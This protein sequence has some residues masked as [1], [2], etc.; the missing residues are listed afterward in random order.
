LIGL[1]QALSARGIY[2]ETI[3]TDL[4]CDQAAGLKYECLTEF[5]SINVRYFPRSL[6][7][8]FPRD[9]AF[10]PRL[11]KWLR[12]HVQDYDIINIHGLFSYPN[13]IASTIAHRAKVPYVIR[14]CGM[15]DPW[16]LGQ[17]RIKK[18]AYL[19]LF[20]DRVLRHASAISFTSEEES[21][22]SYKVFPPPDSVIIPLGVSP[23]W[24][25]HEETAPLILPLDKQIILF[26]SR[27][28][29][30]KGLDLLLPALAR[31]KEERDDFLCVIAGGGRAPYE[32]KIK[33]EV[34]MN[35]LEDVIQFTGFVKGKRKK[36]LL[37]AASCFVLPSY[38]ENF[39][40]SVAEAMAAAC[41]V[42]ISDQVNI[43]KEVS[44]AF[45][46]R[47]VRCNVTDLFNAL[48]EVLS[49]ASSRREMGGNGQTLVKEK[50]NWDR[51]SEKV[52]SLYE[53]CIKRQYGQSDPSFDVPET[54]YSGN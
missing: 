27:L 37:Q 12:A 54:K 4:G 11:A 28:D 39:G 16:C 15:L 31:L 5:H 32:D 17:S 34:K 6:S 40:V 33:N 36:Q 21:R 44:T 13:S 47:V 50:F 20:E 48:N 29:E 2:S 46:G 53:T 19:R 7:A 35:N 18:S 38:Q 26:L 42:I 51:I 49:D 1:S 9:F 8:W 3:T 43:H 52:I 41:P 14:P 25:E 24:D 22:V 30:K 10:S 23:V 45:A